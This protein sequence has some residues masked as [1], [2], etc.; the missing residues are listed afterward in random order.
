MAVTEVDAMT[1][2]TRDTSP[3]APPA[4]RMSYEE[5]LRTDEEGWAEWVDGWVVPMSPPSTEHKLVRLWLS[6]VLSVFVEHRRLGTVLAAP[7]QMK[8]GPELPGREPDILF[9]AKEHED[10]LR[11]NHLEGPADLA[12]EIVS[13]ESGGRDRGD[14]FY[15]YERGGVR[16]YW[17]I[18]PQR[19]QVEFYQRGADGL[20]HAVLPVDGAYHSAVLEGLWIRE[21]WLWQ[22]P[23]P[24]L[25][26]I[27][28]AWGLQ[29]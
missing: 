24:A 9:V 13:P 12:V 28:G 27:L 14:K 5:F 10:R 26:E 17:L 16:E 3:P 11:K 29:P 20:Y 21:E 7:Y 6:K 2:E 23:R 18:D 22:S 25:L 8:T 1:T 4:R 19:R 15:E